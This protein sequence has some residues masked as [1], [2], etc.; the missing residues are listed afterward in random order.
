MRNDALLCVAQKALI[1]KDGE[2]LV[3]NDPLLGLDLPGGKI[4][5]EEIDLTGALKREVKEETGI[6]I[7]VGEPFSVWYYE[8][9]NE[10]SHRNK[11]KKIYTVAFKCKYLSGDVKLSDE[12]NLF[13]WVN[14]DN[15]SK[16]KTETN[17]YK[18]LEEY[19]K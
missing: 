6:E 14:K 17:M 11:G 2:V 18:A 10:S 15:Y 7:E 12:H 3:L 8:F 9:S 1:D 13:E 19:F 5:E 4:Q 16:L